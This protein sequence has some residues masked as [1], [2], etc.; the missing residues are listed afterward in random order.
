MSRHVAAFPPMWRY[1]NWRHFINK[2][3]IRINYYH[4]IKT[5]TFFLQAP[6]IDDFSLRESINLHT[7]QITI[8][9]GTTFHCAVFCVSTST[10]VSGIFYGHSKDVCWYRLMTVELTETKHW[11]FL[12]RFY[13]SSSSSEAKLKV[14]E[15]NSINYQSHPFDWTDMHSS[16]L[17]SDF[18]CVVFLS[19]FGVINGPNSKNH[20]NI[21]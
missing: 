4:S 17:I 1:S 7:P 18:W 2:H 21:N 5:A 12:F 14:E 19:S 8:K 15:K 6:I 11:K 10:I 13:F 3:K 20:L 16:C 9:I